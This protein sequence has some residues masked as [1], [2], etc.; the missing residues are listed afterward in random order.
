[1]KPD[2]KVGLVKAIYAAQQRQLD[3]ITAK[4]QQTMQESPQKAATLYAYAL[5]DSSDVEKL[6]QDTHDQQK[7]AVN[8][9]A[10]YIE[11]HSTSGGVQF[12]CK[13]AC[14][15]V[16]AAARGINVFDSR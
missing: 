11:S 6:R 15:Q 14:H 13:T 2:R 1:M 4:I 7:S 8:N 12:N 16:I 5:K 9:A 3:L 10:G